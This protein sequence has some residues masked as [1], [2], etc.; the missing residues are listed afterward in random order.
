[1]ATRINWTALCVADAEVVSTVIDAL[2]EQERIAHKQQHTLI[3]AQRNVKVAVSVHVDH[4]STATDAL[5][6]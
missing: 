1:M 2:L 4:Q 5:L 3:M 6:S